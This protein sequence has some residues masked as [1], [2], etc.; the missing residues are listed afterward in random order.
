MYGFGTNVCPLLFLFIIYSWIKHSHWLILSNRA[1]SQYSMLTLTVSC[2]LI[3]QWCWVLLP[4]ILACKTMLVIPYEFFLV[5][6]HLLA[7]FP[8]QLISYINRTISYQGFIPCM[9]ALTCGTSEAG[10][11]SSFPH[12]SCINLG[13]V[14]YTIYYCGNDFLYGQN[15]DNLFVHARLVI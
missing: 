14:V 13:Y 5:M 2:V 10:V 7:K 1:V 11:D 3:E 4:S 12:F 9:H 15:L 8:F 6:E